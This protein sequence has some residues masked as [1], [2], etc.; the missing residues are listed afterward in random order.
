VHTAARIAAAA[1]GGE[2]LISS[3]SLNHDD[4]PGQQRELALKGLTQPVQV[5]AVNWRD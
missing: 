5:T 1:A 3:T 4:G 2:I